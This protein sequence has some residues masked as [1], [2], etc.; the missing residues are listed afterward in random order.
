[1]RPLVEHGIA[2]GALCIQC[3]RR[4]DCRCF[5]RRGWLTLFHRAR[6]IGATEKTNDLIS[7]ARPKPDA[8]DAIA[9]FSQSANIESGI[10][11]AL[12]Q[13]HRVAGNKDRPIR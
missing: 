7:G 8:G 13:L 2:I 4:N 1:M 3:R 5:R 12:A 6:G 9:R 11:S 10:G